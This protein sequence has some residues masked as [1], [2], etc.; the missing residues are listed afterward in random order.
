MY[1]SS[2]KEAY[3]TLVRPILEYASA[4]WDPYQQYLI[5][6]MEMIQRQAARWVK[7][8]YRL[9]SS[10]SDMINNLQWTSLQ[11]RRMYSRLTIFCRFLHQDRPDIRIPQY[12]P[13]LTL[14][15]YHTSSV[16]FHLSVHQLITTRRASSLMLLQIGITYQMK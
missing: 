6:N 5:N 3:I 15:I 1:T 8:D 13:Y 4:V 10:I 7:Q 11:K 9:T 14:P 12:Y 2:V 16:S